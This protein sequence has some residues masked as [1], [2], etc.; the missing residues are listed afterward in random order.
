MCTFIYSSS[1]PSLQ[2]LLGKDLNIDPT[3]NGGA[4][5]VVEDFNLVTQDDE[6]SF[7]GRLDLRRCSIFRHWM[8][9][10]QSDRYWV[11]WP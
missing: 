5:L 9:R 7:Q 1:D 2:K 11:S 3:I 4:L 8:E 10:Q 6:V